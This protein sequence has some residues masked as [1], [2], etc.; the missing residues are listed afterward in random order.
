V[1][2][3]RK[4]S[5]RLT[6]RTNCE[7]VSPRDYRLLVAA[8]AAGAF[9][10]ALPIGSM[11][12]EDCDGELMLRTR[13]SR[14]RFE[15]VEAIGQILSYAVLHSFHISSEVRHTPRITVDRLTICRE[16][17]NF[18]AA[19]LAFAHEEDDAKRF[20]GARRM[21]RQHGLPRFI[22]VKSPIETKPIYVDFDSPILINLFA[23]M[24]RRTF[25]V[26]PE[27][28]ISAT[29]MFP[30][31]GQFWLVDHEGDLYTSELRMVAVDLASTQATPDRVNLS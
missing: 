10:R 1:P 4:T 22:F 18:L 14:L 21:M 3:I 20:L 25:T 30:A 19:E 5:E 15:I 23:K 16:S 9:S 24:V 29:E 7:F 28:L 8:D 27:A 31:H 11:V 26:R 6:S 12:V 2:V 13:D 17:W